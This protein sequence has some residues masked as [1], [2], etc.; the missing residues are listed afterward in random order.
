MTREGKKLRMWAPS[1]V[2]NGCR[3]TSSSRGREP[4]EA[5]GGAKGSLQS[6]RCM[7]IGL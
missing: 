3:A 5:E 7:Y 6:S 1:N 2:G 4:V